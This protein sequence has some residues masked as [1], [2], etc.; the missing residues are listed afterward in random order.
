MEIYRTTV[1]R[2]SGT[3]DTEITAKARR[4]YKELKKKSRRRTYV[5][6]AY[7]NNQKVFLDLFWH[8]LSEKNAKDRNRRLR[9]YPC[10][11]D[12]I[13]HSRAQPSSKRNPN[14]SREIVHRF[15]GITPDRELFY[16]QIKEDTKRKQKFF[17]SVFPL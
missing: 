1:K 15:A 14:K 11:I 5:R 6:S 13:Q 16:V 4:Q 2:Y 8:H 17:L 7:F 3:D 12:L 9:Y 10:A